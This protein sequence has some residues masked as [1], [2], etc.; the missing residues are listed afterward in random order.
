MGKSVFQHGGSQS[1]HDSYVFGGALIQLRC[2]CD[3]SLVKCMVILPFTPPPPFNEYIKRLE[4]L[5]NTFINIHETCS[6]SLSTIN[7]KS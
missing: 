2:K 7:W 6:I 4:L 5:I 3:G 1:I